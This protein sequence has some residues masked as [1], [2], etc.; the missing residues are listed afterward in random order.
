MMKS[1]IV[2]FFAAVSLLVVG[3]R[4]APPKTRVQAYSIG[5][6]ALNDNSKLIRNYGGHAIRIDDGTAILRMFRISNGIKTLEFEYLLDSSKHPMAWITPRVS[7]NDVDIEFGCSE[8]TKGSYRMGTVS[9][10]IIKKPHVVGASRT[11]CSITVED[12][13]NELFHYLIMNEEG[14][15]IN[16]S[17][18]GSEYAMLKTSKDKPADFLIVTIANK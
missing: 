18:E 5:Q 6:S 2:I 8:Q 13:Q 1:L 4:E 16:A 11:Y 7:G 14:I 17:E 15:N 9:Q 12:N 10:A 3:C